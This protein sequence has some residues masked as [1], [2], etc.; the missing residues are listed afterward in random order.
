MLFKYKNNNIYIIILN[1]KQEVL[2][3]KIDLH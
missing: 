1:I 2:I 3:N